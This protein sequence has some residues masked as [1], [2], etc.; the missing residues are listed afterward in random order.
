MSAKRNDYISKDD[1]YMTMAYIASLRSKDPNTQVG[2]VIVSDT[3]RILSVGYNGFPNGISDDDFPWNREADCEEDTKY[4]YVVHAEANA[5]M[6]FRGDNKALQSATLYVTLFPC[7]ECTKMII[8]SGI[9]KI[10]YKSNKYSRTAD[11]REAKK[12]LDAV[13]IECIQYD[14]SKEESIKICKRIVSYFEI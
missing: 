8:Q 2:A 3:D 5:I 14:I 6:N 1:M 11:F 13:G 4:P 7:H 12:M 10:V 9:K